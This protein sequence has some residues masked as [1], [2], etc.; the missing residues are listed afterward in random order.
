MKRTHIIII[1]LLFLFILHNSALAANYDIKVLKGDNQR[2]FVGSTSPQ[3]IIVKV[4]DWWGRPITTDVSFKVIKGDGSFTKKTV[5]TNYYGKAQ[6]YFKA[7]LVPGDNVIRAYMTKSPSVKADFNIKVTLGQVDN[8]PALPVKPAKVEKKEETK[9]IGKEKKEEKPEKKEEPEKPDKVEKPEEKKEEPKKE[10]KT[11][12]KNKFTSKIQPRLV[13][14]KK[15]KP[16]T[17]GRRP[18]MIMAFDGHNQRIQPGKVSP[19]TIEVQVMD[20]NGT[21]L[22]GVLITYEIIEGQAKVTSADDITDKRGRARTR[23]K[24]GNEEGIV[25][26]RARV[27]EDKDLAAIFQVRIT[28]GTFQKKP[29]QVEKPGK[30]EKPEK[31]ETPKITKPETTPIPKPEYTPVPKPEKTE[32][33]KV[34]APSYDPDKITIPKDPPRPRGHYS[35]EP[36]KISVVGG[37]FQSSQA[38]TKLPQPVVVYVSDADDN[39]AEATVHFTVLGGDANVTSQQVNTDM[40]GLASTF[41]VVNSPRPIKIVAEVLEKPGLAT[42]VYANSQDYNNSNNNSQPNPQIKSTTPTNEPNYPA[43][44]SFYSL[45]SQNTTSIE[46]TKVIPLEI[47]VVDFRNQ[48]LSTPIRFTVIKGNVSVLNPVVQTNAEGKGVCYVDIGNSMGIFT[49]EAQSLENPDLKAEFR[50][51]PSIQTGPTSNTKVARPGFENIPGHDTRPTVTAPPVDKAS[52]KPALIAVMQG[53]GQQGQPG[54]K[55]PQPL[56]VLVTDNQGNPISGTM[57]AF[58]VSKGAARVTTPFIRTNNE[59]KASTYVILG[60]QPGAVEIAVKVQDNK[61]LQTTIQLNAVK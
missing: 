43:A 18:A 57:V 52:G 33:P 59:G 58:V 31:T 56:Q 45:K 21:P 47:G 7:G 27:A 8:T 61:A 1:L 28:D 6:V 38:G 36:A 39:P 14:K 34:N 29:V 3:P 26:I 55:L 13:V 9:K 53:G 24:A 44:I 40:R 49:V 5:R 37:N 10:E 15:D 4:V 41:V 16:E 35:R 51:G 60:N 54:Q 30:I 19:G 46:K 11:E 20:D 25:T 12:K 22:P 23:L 32:T 42:V 2:V 48:P 17:P 50:S